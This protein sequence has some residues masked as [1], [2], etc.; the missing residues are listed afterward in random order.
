M[1]NPYDDNDNEIYKPEKGMAYMTKT[2]KDRIFEY[3]KKRPK[4]SLI[5]I[6][7]EF[8]DYPKSTTRD[9]YYKWQ[10]LRQTEML[11][12]DIRTM[13]R[14]FR[15]KTKRYKELSDNELAAIMRL[16]QYA[17]ED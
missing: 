2:K 5:E 15:K 11:K 9:I 17:M 3:F 16:E 14:I 8:K 13:F 4:A 6:Y 7:Q 10:K 12:K 1:P